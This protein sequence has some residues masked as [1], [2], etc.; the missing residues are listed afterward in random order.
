ML[1]DLILFILLA[2]TAFYIVLGG[3]IFFRIFRSFLDNRHA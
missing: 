1:T 3:L 2:I